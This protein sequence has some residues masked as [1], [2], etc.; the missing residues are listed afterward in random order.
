MRTRC[1]QAS[2]LAH[3]A[4]AQHD[5]HPAGQS[6]SW[7]PVNRQLPSVDHIH[8]DAARLEGRPL[9]A[10]IVHRGQ[11]HLQGGGRGWGGVCVWCVCVGG[12]LGFEGGAE[13]RARGGEKAAHA[14]LH[15]PPCSM[16]SA[17]PRRA[18]APLES[19]RKGRCALM[20]AR[21]QRQA[22]AAEGESKAL[23]RESTAIHLAPISFRSSA[24][25]S[26]AHDR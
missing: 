12:G 7:G 21:R 23:A 3:A 5:P 9:P 25:G 13:A 18:A 2:S 1:A 20:G 14:C 10:L 15:Q 4:R 16:A 26:A 19:K 24:S 8:N 6:D 11:E 17:G 22:R